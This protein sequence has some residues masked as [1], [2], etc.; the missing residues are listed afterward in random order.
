MTPRLEFGWYLPTSGDTVCYGDRSRD[1]PPSAAL[2]DRV[3]QA[4]E[5][6]GF[7][8]F[9]VPV[10]AP[11]WEAFTASAMAVAKTRRIKALVASRPGYIAPVQ[12]AKMVAT[13]DQL[14]GGRIAVN[15]IAGQ[16]EA[17]TRAEG[18]ALAKEDRYAM[19]AEEVAIMKALWSGQPVD[20]AGRFH[21]LSGARV[22][23]PSLQQPSPRFYL[24]G[25]SME[26]WEV[27]ARHADVHLFWGDTPERIAQNITQL[28][29][30]AE[31]HGRGDALQ[32]GMRLQICCRETEAEAWASAEA[33]VAGVT[34]AQTEKLRA[35]VA[36]SAANARVQELAREHGA[37]IAQH[38]WTGISRARPGAGIMVV[39]DPAQCAATLQRFVDAGCTS[40]CL[41]GYLH[42]E[43]AA[44]FAR[45]VRP[46]MAERN[47]GRMLA[48]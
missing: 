6:A 15:L 13:F 10:G 43:E 45:W 30:M 17:E 37:L 23:P 41:S 31:A 27:S 40:F 9:L 22:A 19:M 11:C 44:R 38:L 46:I 7:E 4:A 3:V 28:R 39:G 14:S 29:A 26:A 24:G 32:F 18:I 20:Y 5:A 12:F 36:A 33:L 1:I 47:Q 8:Y 34:E 21:T 35:H 2:F 42:D 16:S 25:G 48:A